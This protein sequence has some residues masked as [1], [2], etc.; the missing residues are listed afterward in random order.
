MILVMIF[1]AL[2]PKIGKPSSGL[3][4]ILVIVLAIALLWFFGAFAAI[5]SWWNSPNS[6]EKPIIVKVYEVKSDNSL[7][8]REQGVA[9]FSCN[10]NYKF[11][12]FATGKVTIFYPGEGGVKKIKFNPSSPQKIPGVHYKGVYQFREE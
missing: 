8:L 11:Q 2:K 10:I 6:V 5:S 9:P 1:S 4:K 3:K 7:L 12:I